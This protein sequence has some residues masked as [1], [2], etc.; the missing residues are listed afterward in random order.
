MFHVIRLQ[1]SLLS[2]VESIIKKV[3]K[4]ATVRTRRASI[5]NEISSAQDRRK[6]IDTLRQNLFE[7]YASG[8]VSQADYLF[9]KSRYDDEYALIECR[10]EQLADEK[11]QLPETNPKQNKW[12]ATFS[13]FQKEKELSREMLLALVEKIYVNE[14]KQI[15]IILKYQDEMKKLL[16]KGV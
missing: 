14:D 2:D 16:H 12:F 6:R 1:I 15:H 4:S 13:R 11:A 10:L 9:G 7:S 5:D 8:I 3:E